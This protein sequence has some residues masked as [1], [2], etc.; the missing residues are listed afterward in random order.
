MKNQYSKKDQIEQFMGSLHRAL[1]F[2]QQVRG[3]SYPPELAKFVEPLQ[4]LFSQ[5]GD[6]E[7]QY[8]QKQWKQ[9]QEEQNDH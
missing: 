6:I 4:H 7:V 3:Y 8:F 9:E 5:A 1:T 2:A